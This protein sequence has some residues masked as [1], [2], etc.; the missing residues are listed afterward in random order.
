MGGPSQEHSDSEL[1]RE[2]AARAHAEQRLR[3]LRDLGEEFAAVTM[4]YRQLLELVARRMGELIGESCAIRLLDA[5]SDWF[6]TSGAIYH[7]Q[8]ELVAVVRALVFSKRTRAHEGFSGVILAAGK[9]VC[10]PH[11]APAQL[12]AMVQPE[13]RDRLAL[14][15]VRSM[16]GVPL[17][18]HGRPLGVAF[19]ARR[20]GAPPFT[21]QDEQL[22]EDVAGHA[23]LAISNAFLFEKQERELAERRTL[24]DRLAL[25]SQLSRE[26]TEAT[27]SYRGLLE[28]VARRLAEVVGES[29][30]LRL[31]A[32]DGAYL[33]PPCGVH[34][35]D[36]ERLKVL[37]QL[38]QAKPQ[39]IGDG[40]VG[41]VARTGKS[42][43]IPQLDP[44]EFAAGI[45]E[46]LRPLA[47]RIDA[48]S[49]LA[50]PLRWRAEVLGVVSMSRMT[51]G[52][53]YTED[54]L[55]L[56]ED[57]AAHASLA[58]AN[59]RLLEAAQ[60]ELAERKKAEEK[61]QRSEEQFRQA[62]KMEAVGRLAGGVAHD[63]NNLLT[64]ILG[65]CELLSTVVPSD[66][67]AHGCV[68][69]IERASQRAAELTRQLL[70]LSR[71]QVQTLQVLELNDAVRSGVQMLRRLIGENIQVVVHCAEGGAKVKAD[72]GHLQQVL[73]NLV[74]NAR[75]AMPDGG[76][77]TIETSHVEL[78]PNYAAE[79]VNVTPGRYVLLA[80]SD[81]GI[82]MDEATRA[83]IF[84]PFFTTK[85]QGKG[86]GLG[87][88][89]VLGIVQQ[90]GGSV[91][92]YS[93]PG[94]GSTFKVYL[95]SS[96]EPL[97]QARAPIPIDTLTGSETIL[98]AED[99]E[100]LRTVTRHILERA[101]Y[102][103]IMAGSGEEALRCAAQYQG[104][105]DLLLTDVVM[106]RMS[107]PE[108][109]RACAETRPSLRALCMSGYTGEAL[110]SQRA[111]PQGLEL[112]EKPLTAERLLSKIRELL[113][114]PA[115]DHAR[116]RA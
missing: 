36:P 68:Q 58:I 105:I 50:V 35:V 14:F 75:D 27:H 16:L 6:E 41:E 60:H 32:A 55:R 34:D 92:A 80:V 77:L 26:F 89:T 103:V 62:Q 7:P 57:I 113:T 66:D 90:S 59:S 114:A 102:R 64:V 38:T 5:D 63:F 10:L 37:A 70:A 45:P 20:E 83:R 44:A 88:S 73:T 93:E 39:R 25:L 91:W 69:E 81:T 15:P 85:E 13:L 3:L 84:E 74:V 99:D 12:D 1:D 94:A 87:L 19:M 8:P 47:E 111:L 71:Q 33:T 28:L 49:F 96:E 101:G 98:F 30:A 21:A 86:T 40:L 108:L 106:P 109:V 112:L 97:S 82:G 110:S 2:R 107:G 9:P 17:K 22:L 53:P 67:A 29:C 54:D 48:K 11:I 72:A 79:H 104:P 4:G 31:V 76:I 24:T 116:E 51:P 42:R 18:A 46:Q 115:V 100:Q 95:P 61:L 78:D 65:Y 56:V 43:L 23:A 52:R